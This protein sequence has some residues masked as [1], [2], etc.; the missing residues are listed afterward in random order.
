LAAVWAKVEYLAVS[1][2]IA[3]FQ[4]RLKTERLLQRR[5]KQIKKLLKVDSAEKPRF[6]KLI[7]Y[8]RKGWKGFCSLQSTE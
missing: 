8:D 7:S 2:A 5:A 6:D 4:N 1:V 3:R